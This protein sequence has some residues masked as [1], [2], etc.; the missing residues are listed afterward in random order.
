MFCPNCDEDITPENLR[1]KRI[2]TVKGE[3]VEIDD[4]FHRC[5]ACSEEWSEEGFDAAAEAYR[6]YRQAHGMLQP[7]EIRAFRK[8]LGLSQEEMAGLLGW[9]EATVNR[10]EKGALQERSH[11]LALKMAHT[12]DALRILL[13]NRR[14]GI[15]SEKWSRL[16]KS[17]SAK[18]A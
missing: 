6:A 12:N 13:E 7:E 18:S 1:V 3:D 9:S 5:P 4:R 8:N 17:T 11:D 14:E 2:F 15:P 10:Y 16:W